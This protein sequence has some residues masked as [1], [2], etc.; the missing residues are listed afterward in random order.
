MGILTSQRECVVVVA[1]AVF[2]PGF[3]AAS[4]RLGDC[5]RVSTAWRCT[6]IRFTD[7]KAMLDMDGHQADGVSEA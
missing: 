1:C 5:R 7:L 4:R 3:S 6:N 2:V